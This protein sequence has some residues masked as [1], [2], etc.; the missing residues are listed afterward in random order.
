[1]SNSTKLIF[2]VAILLLIYGYVCR[3]LDFYVF[4]DSKHF[5][6]IML[7]IGFLGFLIDQRRI[8]TAQNKNIF[9]VRL[10]V[11]IIVIAFAAVAS[12][13][14]IIRESAGYKSTIEDIRISSEIKSEIGEVRSF[15][16]FL[17]GLSI[18]TIINSLSSGPV[19]FIITVRGSHGIKDVEITLDNVIKING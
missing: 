12:T 6:W 11:A 10:G 19:K 14:I 13:N 1:M 2:I 18:N 5:G 3:L 8:R 16:L 15:G 4:W 17:S 7:A 9:W